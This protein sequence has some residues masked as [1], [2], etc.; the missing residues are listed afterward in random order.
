M[1]HLR[2]TLFFCVLLAL[3]AGAACDTSPKIEGPSRMVVGQRVTVELGTGEGFVENDFLLVDAS[4]REYPHSHPDLAYEWE[5]DSLFRFTVPYGITSGMATVTVG[6]TAGDDYVFEL[7]IVRLFGVVDTT[8]ILSF[9]DLDAPDQQYSSYPVGAGTGYVTLSAE[10]DRL[11]A[12]SAVTGE[13][14]FLE[15]S[16]DDLR[17]FAPSVQ[18]GVN[19]GRGALLPRGA[20]VAS[21]QGVGYISRLPDGSLVL[22]S[23][24]DTGDVLTVAAAA[25]FNRIVA[26]GSTLDPTAI[27]VMHRID[28][29]VEPPELI[30]PPVVLGGA[31]G[32]IKDVIVTP[33]GVLGVA[34]NGVDDLLI[35]VVF[36]AMTPTPNPQQLPEGDEGASR[37]A[38]SADSTLLAVLC[39]TSKTVAIYRAFQGG[40][41]HDISLPVDPRA[42]PAQA[43]VDAGFAPD[44]VL[45]VLLADGA[46]S[47]IDLSSPDDPPV[48]NLLRDAQTNAG[49]ALLVQ[50]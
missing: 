6:A 49:T 31:A 42:T 32:G 46:V 25:K 7:E 19:L 30:E 50:P 26:V 16:A 34:I 8:G 36:E 4:G 3:A 23:W 9:Y 43:P 2:S 27:N 28:A 10:G 37:L 48:V 40:F 38:V 44:S 45:Y 21:E 15:L 22:D 41:T 18:L 29:S 20:V 33:D 5:H 13:I 24:M 17:P 39:E 35:D 11:I 14:H 47:R 12:V 1:R